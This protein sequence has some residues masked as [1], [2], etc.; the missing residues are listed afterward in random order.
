MSA[1]DEEREDEEDR[2]DWREVN[3]F[4]NIVEKL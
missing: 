1:M 4:G 3:V 2:V